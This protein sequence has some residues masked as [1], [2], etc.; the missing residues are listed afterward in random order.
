MEQ[1]PQVLS[2]G[3]VG[4]GDEKNWSPIVKNKSLTRAHTKRVQGAMEGGSLRSTWSM[5]GLNE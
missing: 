2:A 1:L 4:L 3:L 5:G